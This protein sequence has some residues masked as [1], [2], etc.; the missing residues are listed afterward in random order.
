MIAEENDKILCSV[1]NPCEQKMKSLS[2]NNTAIKQERSVPSLLILILLVSTV[3]S[4]VL[5][6]CITFAMQQLISPSSPQQFIRIS[7]V[8]QALSFPFWMTCI[9]WLAARGGRTSE[10]TWITPITML[11][12]CS[13]PPVLSLLVSV[14]LNSSTSNI[15]TSQV[16]STLFMQWTSV[17]RACLFMYVFLA[18]AFRATTLHLRPVDAA[19][20]PHRLT[21]RSIIMLTT[22]V[23]FGL[24]IDGLASKLFSSNTNGANGLLDGFNAFLFFMSLFYEMAYT[25]LW[26]SFA[27]LLA[28]RNPR[29]WYGGFGVAGY[30][31]FLVLF[32]FVF[33][34]IMIAQATIPAGATIPPLDLFYS[35][36]QFA[37]GVL[38]MG[39]VF[40][41]V[42]MMHVAGYRWDI[43]RLTQK[44]ADPVETTSN[45]I[46][47]VLVS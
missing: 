26:F 28:Y 43:L 37:I 15:W 3:L 4:I 25:L 24:S 1:R 7:L 29:R 40:L 10:A 8:S 31:M 34:P 20:S 9:V 38:H 39:I 11:I 35:L 6:Y 5:Q 41:C 46:P 44:D 22:L 27:W 30:V 19:P 18:F 36:V 13:M 45:G 2:M 42:G 16:A 33:L 32:Q 12:F 21:I 17:V 23:A 14:L 47:P